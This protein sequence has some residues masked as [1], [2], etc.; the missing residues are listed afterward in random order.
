VLWLMCLVSTPIIKRIR[1]PMVS[2]VASLFISSAFC[3]LE[4]SLCH[5]PCSYTWVSVKL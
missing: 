5:G 4:S 1:L 2:H 3:V